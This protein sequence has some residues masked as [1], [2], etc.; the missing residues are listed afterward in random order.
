MSPREKV[1]PKWF[2]TAIW[3]TQ[4][5]L[6]IL[7]YFSHID[8]FKAVHDGLINR[9]NIGNAL[10]SE[11]VT[12]FV[13]HTCRFF[14]SFRCSTSFERCNKRIYIGKQTKKS[15]Y[16][17]NAK[18]INELI[19]VEPSYFCTFDAVDAINNICNTY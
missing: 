1:K 18:V 17:G 4:T 9:S 15:I 3:S 11:I 10:I 6:T 13:T 12:V 14:L 16:F 8:I 5:L 2:L 7:I 19:N